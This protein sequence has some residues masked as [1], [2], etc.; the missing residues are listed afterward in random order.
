VKPTDTDIDEALRRMRIENGGH[1][2]YAPAVYGVAQ[3]V[4]IERL[5]A[6]REA[7]QDAA[8]GAEYLLMRGE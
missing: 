3:E 5:T 2:P 6:E 1:E 7:G 4:L 8:G